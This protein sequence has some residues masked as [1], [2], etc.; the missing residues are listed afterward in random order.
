[1][2]GN[3]TFAALRAL[4][5]RGEVVVSEH[6]YDELANDGLFARE[7]VEGFVGGRFRS[8]SPSSTFCGV[9]ECR[10]GR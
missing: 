6:G 3:D 1:M 8:S 9:C 7:I 4:I 10:S 5:G 2:T